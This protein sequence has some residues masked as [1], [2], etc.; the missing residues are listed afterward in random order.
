MDSIYVCGPHSHAATRIVADVLRR[1]GNRVHLP[2]ELCEEEDLRVD[3]AS[4]RRKCIEA[5]EDAAVVVVYVDAYGM[6]SAWEIG[7]AA[8]AGK[9]I[10]GISL[11]PSALNTPHS[12]RPQTAWDHWMHGWKEHS[13]VTSVEAMIPHVKSQTVYFSLP[14]RCEDALGEVFEAAEREAEQVYTPRRTIRGNSLERGPEVGYAAR[15]RCIEAIERS[16]VVLVYL[17]DFGMDSAW[18][19]GYAEK[20]GKRLVGI[21]CDQNKLNAPK[22]PSAKTAWDHWMHGWTEQTVLHGRDLLAACFYSESNVQVPVVCAIVEKHD[23][24]VLKILLQRRTKPGDTGFYGV[25]E[26][27]GGKV[28]KNE[29]IA[30]AT[31]REVKEECGLD[32]EVLDARTSVSYA[33]NGS[34]AYQIDPIAVSECSGTHSYIGIFSVCRV[35]GG[36]LHNTEEGQDHRWVSLHELETLLNCDRCLPVVVPGLRQYLSMM[37][38]SRATIQVP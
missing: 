30:D 19:I 10:V 21:S 29:S 16:S 18:E 35:S 5:I 32:V 1:A 11:D 7:Y 28:A 37:N 33:L 15:W 23:D 31:V 8:K 3:A 26:I 24:G 4:I 13:V 38:R 6:D 25:I 20:A 9:R 14:I 22:A 17:D 34:V 2:A 36:R 12:L 27:P